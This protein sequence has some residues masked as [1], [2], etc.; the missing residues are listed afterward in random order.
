MTMSELK[1]MVSGE[2]IAR[3]P[4]TAKIIYD[5]EHCS[6]RELAIGFSNFDLQIGPIHVQHKSI[7]E[8][9]QTIAAIKQSLDQVSSASMSLVSNKIA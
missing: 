1:I 2:T 6:T 5:Q 8:L 7:K 9:M 3:L 4:S